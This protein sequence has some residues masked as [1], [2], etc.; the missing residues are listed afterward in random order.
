MSADAQ[1]A[2]SGSVCRKEA[3]MKPQKITILYERLS[4]D[5]GEDGVS[6]SILN[7]KQLLEDYAERNGLTPY[8]HIQDDG[9]SGTRWDRPGWQELI[10]KVEADEVSC[11]CVKDS[12]R[13]GRDYLRAGLYREFFHEKNVRLIAI[14]DGID[15]A[16]KEDDFAPFREIMAEWYAR[17]CSKKIKSVYHHKGMAGERLTHHPL[18]GYKK[19]DTGKN[20]QWVIDDSAAEIVKRIFRMTIEGYSVGEIANILS[21]GK[22]ECPSYHLAQ[23]GYGQH[24]NKEFDDPYRWWASAPKDILSKIEYMG[25][26]ANFKGE[27]TNFKSKKYIGKPREDW[28]IFE[29]TH[30]PIIDPETWATANRIRSAAKRHVDRISGEAHPLTGLMFCSDCGAK[31]YHQRSNPAAK[32]QKNDYVCATY[33]KHTVG[34]CTPHRI[35]QKNVME[36]ILTALRTVVKYAVKDE[37]GFKRRVIEMFSAKLAGEVKQQKKRLIACEKRSAELDKLIKKLFEEHTLGSLTDKRFAL[38]SGEYEKEQEDLEREITELRSGID[39][40]VD[41]TERAEK[42]LAL[43]KRCTDFTE[44]TIP[45]LNEFVERVVVHERADK[46]CKHTEQRIDIYLNFIGDFA[47]PHE[48]RDPLDLEEEARQEAHSAS[49]QKRRQYHRDYYR[50]CKENG[51]KTLAELD[52]RTPEQ[53][54]ADEAEKLEQQKEL[55]REYEREYHRRKSAEKRTGEVTAQNSVSVKELDTEVI[56]SETA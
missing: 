38:L 56:L 43:T 35:M 50:K 1:R 55:R 7:Q 8:I 47:V 11:I 52:K 2:A 46:K 42:F 39:D 19:A 37:D 31:M 26:T 3:E 12:S 22:V 33:R 45:M 9:W 36:L 34:D 30:E 15:T 40:Y 44:L 54:A 13:I 16:E 18:Y 6:N 49:V 25:H 21:D 14:N 41:S 29:N 20:S 4:R 32:S 10:S 5:D 48:A 23:M 27:K 17:D 28:V 24:A 53:I 51:V